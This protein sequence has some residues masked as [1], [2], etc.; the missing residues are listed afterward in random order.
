MQHVPSVV[1]QLR[2]KRAFHAHK[3]ETGASQTDTA[4]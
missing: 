2:A 4:N 1:L 3:M